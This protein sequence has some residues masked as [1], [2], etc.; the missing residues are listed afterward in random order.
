MD[1]FIYINKY[2][3]DILYYIIFISFYI[4]FFLGFTFNIG[5]LSDDIKRSDFMDN[6]VKFGGLINNQDYNHL[7]TV[8]T[9]I[10]NENI[11]NVS[12]SNLMW[13]ERA[14]YTWK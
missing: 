14:L 5:L 10:E 12:T 13:L 6:I 3:N 8:N 1:R 11:K 4:I 2:M 9:F 7:L